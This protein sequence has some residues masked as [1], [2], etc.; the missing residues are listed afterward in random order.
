VTMTIMQPRETHTSPYGAVHL[1]VDKLEIRNFTEYAFNNHFLV[2]TDGFSFVIGDE[3]I[4]DELIEGLVP[5]KRVT[6]MINNKPQATGYIDVV[7][8]GGDRS[9]GNTIAIEGRDVFGPVVDSEI[10]PRKRYPDKTPLAKLLEDTLE[11]FGFDTFFLDNEQ[12]ANV[13]AGRAITRPKKPKKKL[14]QY[15]IAQS[16]PHHNE[17]F[18]DFIS[19]ITQREGL[20][21]WPTVEGKGI[22]VSAPDFDQAPRYELRRSNQAQLKQQNNILAGRIRR[23]SVDQP[24]YLV[25]TG[26]IPPTEHQHAPTRAVIDSPYIGT[27]VEVPGLG[28]GGS[29]H[30]PDISRNLRAV[31]FSQIE[32]VKRSSYYT[33]TS[34]IPAP[35]VQT[36]PNQFASLVSKPKFVKDT[37]S[38]TLAQLERFTRRQMSLYL[39]RAFVAEYTVSGH[40]IDGQPIVIDSVVDVHDEWANFHGP[41]WILSRTM[42]KSRAGGTTTTIEAIPLGSLTF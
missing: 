12:N 42:R 32:I 38:R 25:A 2:P 30:A 4:T 28:E 18:F 5:G 41:L 22:V 10:D 21:I 23:D 14:N 17:R 40:E 26:S 13:Q 27:F 11:P 35:P 34:I 39:R 1:L 36:P 24:S 37:E 19:R 20:W 3:H 31:S 29:I 33:F 7:E 16:K 9:S 15:P 8:C 6:L